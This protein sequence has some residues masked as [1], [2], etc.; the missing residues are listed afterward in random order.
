LRLTSTTNDA[1]DFVYKLVSNSPTAGGIYSIDAYIKVEDF[2]GS[3]LQNRGLTIIC[4]YNDNANS[5]AQTQSITG[6]TDGWV[7]REAQVVCPA[8][9][10][11]VIA[12]LY[13]PNATTY[14]DEVIWGTSS[15]V[16]TPTPTNTPTSTA[17]PTSTPTNTPTAT[18]TSTPT[19]TPTFTPVPTVT[20]G[21]DFYQV[22]LPSGGTGVVEM[23]TTAG[24]IF[25]TVAL[26][27]V[28]S[29]GLFEVAKDLAHIASK[30]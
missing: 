1:N 20:P 11:Q 19:N 21:A 28:F 14:Y 25:I 8:N 13:A 7:F 17:T 2:V 16:N 12:Y 22:D 15:E 26:L 30:K 3:A 6:N 27:L 4:Y 18:A 23:K 29:V 9:P 10:S 5:L 24:E